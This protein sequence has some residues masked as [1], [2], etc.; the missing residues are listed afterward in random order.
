M[1]R[2]SRG[3]YRYLRIKPGYTWYWVVI[4]SYSSA[5]IINSF[6]PHDAYRR[7]VYP[8]FFAGWRLQA[9]EMKRTICRMTTTGALSSDERKLMIG[10]C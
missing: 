7:R 3:Q 1:T 4:L 6:R 9:C 2:V 5:I 10:R 8:A